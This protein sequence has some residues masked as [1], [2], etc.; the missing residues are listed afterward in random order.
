MELVCGKTVKSHESP[1]G[2]KSTLKVS[3]AQPLKANAK[4]NTCG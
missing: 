3:L 2:S 1:E 4:T